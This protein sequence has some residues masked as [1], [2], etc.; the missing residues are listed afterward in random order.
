M[1]FSLSMLQ[2]KKQRLLVVGRRG[3][4]G[5]IEKD[6]GMSRRLWE[7]TELHQLGF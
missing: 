2:L 6:S 4:E 1:G 3:G 5:H 7:E